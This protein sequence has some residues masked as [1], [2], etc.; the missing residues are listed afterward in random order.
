MKKRK[1][2]TSDKTD[3]FNDPKKRLEI[4]KRD[5][6]R[7]YYCEE[8]VNKGNATLDH[9]KPLSRGGDNSKENLVTCCLECNAIKSGKTPAEADA[10]L[11]RKYKEKLKRKKHL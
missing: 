11:L 9:S 4:F 7:C 3:Y 2:L 10:L 8:K 1:A 6:W 5:N